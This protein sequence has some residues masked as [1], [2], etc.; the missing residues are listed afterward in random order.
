MNSTNNPPAATGRRT[1]FMEGGN[2]NAI[3]VCDSESET[4][5]ERYWFTSPEYGFAWC[6]RNGC[7]FVYN[8]QASLPVN[9]SLN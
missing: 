9:P 1:L 6:L 4:S 5:T 7:H 8:T 2:P 3:L